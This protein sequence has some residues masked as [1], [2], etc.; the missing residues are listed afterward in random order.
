MSIESSCCSK[1][2]KS[3][4]W[5]GWGG[6]QSVRSRKSSATF[7]SKENLARVYHEQSWA[8][9]FWNDVA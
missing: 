7:S 6:I 3:S 4:N 2:K 1:K 8:M 9:L 5:N